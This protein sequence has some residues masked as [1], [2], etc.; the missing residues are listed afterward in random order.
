MTQTLENLLLAKVEALPAFAYSPVLQEVMALLD[1]PA[2]HEAKLVELVER[3][4]Y[5]ARHMLEVS[6]QH[7]ER[8]V[9]GLE[10]AIRVIGFDA[11]KGLTASTLAPG[12]STVEHATLV[13]MQEAL[14]EHSSRV[15]LAAHLLARETHYPNLSEAYTAGMFHDIGRALLNAFA[16]EELQAT[17]RLTHSKAVTLISAEDQHL[18]FNHAYV[19]SKLLAHWQ[20][21]PAVVE[22][23]RFHHNPRSA[24]L[25]KRLA[26]LLHLADVAVNCQQANLPIGISLFPLDRAVAEDLPVSREKLLELA[27]HADHL[28]KHSSGRSA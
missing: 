16:Y 26:R 3:D 4:R 6:A 20:L 23:V 14:R 5:L 24:F 2:A 9:H 8:F 28:V 18:G 22:A 10:H 19:G 12:V 15:A 17:M 1:D 11:F 7:A 25:N 21:P 13:G 27:R